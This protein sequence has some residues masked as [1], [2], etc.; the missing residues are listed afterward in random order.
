MSDATGNGCVSRFALPNGPRAAPT[1]SVSVVDDVAV[2]DV[3][4]CVFK[5]T[6]TASPRAIFARTVDGQNCCCKHC[7]CLRR[8]LSLQGRLH[9]L[10][11]CMQASQ[12][13]GTRA[14]QCSWGTPSRFNSATSTLPSSPLHLA[15]MLAS[16]RSLGPLPCHCHH[17]ARQE[18]CYQLPH[19]AAGAQAPV[20]R[21]S[22][23]VSSPL[24][25]RFAPRWSQSTAPATLSILACLVCSRAGHGSTNGLRWG[26]DYL[27]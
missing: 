10:I 26:S 18:L 12:K 20:G 4:S 21:A 5:I 13:A 22:C 27:R 16:T 14:R 19:P 11:P 25:K 23:L 1:S 24:G 7:W 9:W 3:S 17:L 6:Q 15:C 8:Q 2:R